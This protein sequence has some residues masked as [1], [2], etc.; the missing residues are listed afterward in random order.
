MPDV[1][2]FLRH[3]ATALERRLAESPLGR[4]NGELHITL[5]RGGLHL[6]FKDGRLMLVEPWSS[7]SYGRHEDAGFPPLVFLQLLFGYRSLDELRFA[8]PDVWVKDEAELLLKTLFPKKP[9][10]VLPLG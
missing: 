4:Y 10:W 5:Y 2:R 1:P 8:F 9:S 6:I 7:A 3:I